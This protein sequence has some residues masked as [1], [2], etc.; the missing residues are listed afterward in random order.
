[1]MVPNKYFLTAIGI[2]FIFAN[3]LYA[4]ENDIEINKKT[5]E[6]NLE[7]TTESTPIEQL[8][9][10]ESS[11]RIRS[12]KNKFFFAISLTAGE[13]HLYEPLNI[14]YSKNVLNG[15]KFASTGY[16]L[17]LGAA[18]HTK[19]AVYALLSASTNLYGKQGYT[20]SD[21]YTYLNI[22]QKA[23]GIG[24]RYSAGKESGFFGDFAGFISTLNIEER[25]NQP[26]NQAAAYPLYKTSSQ[27]STNNTLDGL[28][29]LYVGV[30]YKINVGYEFRLSP[31]WKCAIGLVYTEEHLR[32]QKAKDVHKANTKNHHSYGKVEYLQYKDTKLK[33]IN[34][35]V[36]L[37]YIGG[38]I[39]FLF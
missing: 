19:L 8:D 6:Q 28:A 2:L 3:M 31:E 30:G 15:Q 13:K 26:I 22:Q 33:N 34:E 14:F 24:L 37:Y 1:M 5:Q 35:Q 10:S 21:I 18:V 36:V 20:D 11:D 25:F 23:I 39:S 17:N 12:E 16:E 27:V 9:V 29:I 38:K 7:T 4:Q 32:Y